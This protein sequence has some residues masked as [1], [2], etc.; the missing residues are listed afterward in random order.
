MLIG[1]DFDNTIVCLDGVFHGVAVEQGLMPAEIP[2][3]KVNVRDYLRLSGKEQKWIELQGYVY[4]TRIQDAPP[5]PGVLEFFS[6]CSSLGVPVCIISHKTSYPYQGPKY[7][8]HLAA[9]QW[10]ERNGFRGRTQVGLWNADVYFELTKGEK[11]NRIAESGCTHFIDDLPEFL[12]EPR[13]PEN[14]QRIL[15]DPAG[16]CSGVEGL[17]WTTSWRQIERLILGDSTWQAGAETDE[18]VRCHREQ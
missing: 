9:R 17:H 11:L 2:A 8:L 4:G 6:R 16:Q 12:A 13:F 3:N 18:S 5:F 10:L 1:A 7:D 15:F 14:V